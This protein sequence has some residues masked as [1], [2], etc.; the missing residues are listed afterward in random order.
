MPV[1]LGGP[2]P[3]L[4]PAEAQMHADAVVVGEAEETWP[5]LI[6]DFRQGRMQPLYR[7]AAAPDT[8]APPAPAARP[9]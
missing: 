7:A 1:V 9:A 2:H 8:G 5:L 4:L 3:T 6:E